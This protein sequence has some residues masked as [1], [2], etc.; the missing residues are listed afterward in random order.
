MP[1]R[2]DALAGV[3]EPVVTSLDLELFDLELTGSGARRI[4]R[5]TVDRDGGV[6]LETITRVTEALTP[7]LDNEPSLSGPYALEVSSP[8]L[9][10]PLRKPEHYRRAV[11]S[12]VSV[13]T[14]GADGSTRRRQGA[15]VEADDRNFTLEVDGITE[16]IDYADVTQARTVFEWGPATKPGGAKRKKKK[17]K[18]RT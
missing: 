6:D 8:G 2:V 18:A 9:E 4:L 16:Q 7:V 17:E 11:G 10:R 15:L 13:K 1:E 14:R 5:V 12:T 3:I